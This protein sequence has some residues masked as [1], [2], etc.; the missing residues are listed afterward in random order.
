MSKISRQRG[1]ATELAIA[2]LIG[3]KRAHFEKHDLDHPLLAPEVK[4]RRQGL[5]TLEKW[6]AQAEAAAPA[7]RIPCLIVHAERQ[8]F[9]ESL[10]VMRLDRL[11]KLL[12]L[13]V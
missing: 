9:E 2:K 6:L 10:V 12:P 11:V 3:G 4:H 5:R 13:Q 1:K 8:A 7:E